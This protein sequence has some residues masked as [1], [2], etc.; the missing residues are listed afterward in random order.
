METYL[1]YV[2]FCPAGIPS[3]TFQKNLIL[4]YR[5]NGLISRHLTGISF[6]IHTCKH[7]ASVLHA[8]S[9]TDFVTVSLQNGLLVMELLRISSSSSSFSPLIIHGT[10]PVADG[11]WHNVELFMVSSKVNTAKWIMLLRG[12]VEDTVTSK[13]ESGNLDFFARRCG[14]LSWRPELQTCRLA[15]DWLS[16]YSGDWWDNIAI[17]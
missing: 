4:R 17:L 2:L 13:L 5:G 15:P 9:S 11:K 14:H 10:R 3:V 8:N 16:E 12:N 1:F 7:N 6:S